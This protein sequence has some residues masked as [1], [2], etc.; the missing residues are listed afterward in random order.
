MVGLNRRGG[1]TISRPGPELMVEAG[2][3]VVVITRAG[4]AS[5]RLG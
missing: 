3:G 5:P 1:E 2:D 4:R